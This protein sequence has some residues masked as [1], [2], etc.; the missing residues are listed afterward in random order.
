MGLTRRTCWASAVLFFGATLMT[1]SSACT[2]R[3]QDV[4]IHTGQ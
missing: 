4:A 2:H 1:L 3:G